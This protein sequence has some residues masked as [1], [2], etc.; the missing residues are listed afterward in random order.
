MAQTILKLPTPKGWETTQTKAFGKHV[1]SVLDRFEQTILGLSDISKAVKPINDRVY[2][3][4]TGELWITSP[5]SFAKHQAIFRQH[6]G[7][8]E[9][10]TT[11]KK[12]KLFQVLNGH[13]QARFQFLEK[14]LCDI[15]K[16]WLTLLDTC[17]PMKPNLQDLGLSVEEH[18][19]AVTLTPTL[20]SERLKRADKSGFARFGT[21][22]KRMGETMGKLLAWDRFLEHKNP[23]SNKQNPTTSWMANFSH[24][25][26]SP[27]ILV[28]AKC[29][30]EAFLLATLLGPAYEDPTEPY[31]YNTASLK[32][33]VKQVNH[34]FEG[35]RDHI[36][37]LWD[38][39]LHESK[40][41][42]LKQHLDAE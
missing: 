26:K 24:Q 30:G 10:K 5:N 42:L 13:N 15:H 29:A 32:S 12:E 31:P 6:D 14:T 39:S 22:N 7:M 40:R 18:K 28:D 33:Y 11:K 35:K 16:E 9:H 36:V 23:F 34:L 20:R 3:P 2:A 38:H 19:G 21:S 25:P 27:A 17:G 41:L 8:I 4:E 37:S 1:A